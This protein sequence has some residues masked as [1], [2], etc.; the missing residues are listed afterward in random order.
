MSLIDEKPEASGGLQ[1]STDD[2]G[3]RIT[4]SVG[5][6]IYTHTSIL[7]TAYWFTDQCYVFIDRVEG[8]EDLLRIELR[9]KESTSNESLEIL[10]REF[11]NRLL[12]QRV[13]DIVFKETRKVRDF[14][15]EKAF[16]EGSKHLDP[17][18]LQSDESSIPSSNQ[19]YRD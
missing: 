4:V 15:V 5:L 13:R 12:D 11:C 10:A 14:L 7:K 6:S 3:N 16:F 8:A 19:S 18:L 2:L 17:T 9:N 1:V